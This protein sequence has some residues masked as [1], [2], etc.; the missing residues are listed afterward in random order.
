[1]GMPRKMMIFKEIADL[2]ANTTR[3]LSCFG[4]GADIEELRRYIGMAESVSRRLHMEEGLRLGLINPPEI[5]D[6]D[7]DTGDDIED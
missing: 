6:F 4:N 3:K 1:M 7:D 2:Q 5:E